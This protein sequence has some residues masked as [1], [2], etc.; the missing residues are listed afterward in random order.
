VRR[1]SRK[2]ALEQIIT[3]KM[4]VA[5]AARQRWKAEDDTTS[6]HRCHPLSFQE[7]LFVA[8]YAFV[9]VCG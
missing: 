3:E 6:L 9:H 2:G 4:G 7:F 5:R 1:Q 8:A